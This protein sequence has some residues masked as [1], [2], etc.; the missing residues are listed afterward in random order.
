M[1]GIIYTRVSSGE[2]VEGTSLVFQEQVCRNYCKDKNIE[3]VQVFRE[4]GESAKDLS[5][6]NRQEFLKALDF[7]RK[8]KGEIEAFIVLRL[9]RFARNTED[10]FA[11]RKILVDYGTTLHSVTE[12]IDD[13]PTGKFFET[14]IAG[15]SEYENAIRK[16]QCTDGM[17]T[18]IKQGIYPWQPPVG[19]KCLNAKKHGEKKMLPDPP[20][21]NLFP[22]I[23]KGLKEY[24]TGV[25]TQLE[26]AKKFNE[27]GF[28]KFTGRKATPSV[29]N[30]ILTK[31][32]R[33]Y[34]GIIPNPWDGEE[35]KGKHKPMIT[36]EEMHL[37]IYIRTGKKLNVKRENF[38]PDFPLKGGLILCGEC[39]RPLTGSAS[40]GRK[41]YYPY[42]HCCNKSC[43]LYGKTIKKADLE[44]D[45]QE[46][47]KTITPNDDF[48]AL[49]KETVMDV[50]EE[51]GKNFELEANRCE[52]YLD[53]LREKKKRIFEMREDGSYTKEEF[54]ERKAEI[55]NQI[56][57]AKISFSEA[58]IEQFDIELALTYATKFIKDLGRQWFDMKEN[59]RPRFQKHILPEGISYT[60]S[61][62]FGTATL[63]LVYAINRDIGCD[64]SSL[65][66]PTGLE[67]ATSSVQTRRS[68]R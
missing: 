67:P 38:N 5:L 52:G 21:E 59:L 40:K 48:L 42:Y 45:F 47:L 51:K 13:S 22:I 60:K 62:G 54:D 61:D 18:K 50:W 28:E 24:A 49:F 12:P 44:R 57:S 20:D 3:V 32:L 7:C 19:Y 1:K 16:R 25:Y 34:A 56:A 11:V 9:N 30:R 14:I 2:Q 33:F 68:T 27:W 8:H 35:Y 65:V 63:G 64:K 58:K 36:E 39:G 53:E 37:I 15:A 31:Q 10:H 46:L 55:E 6:N 23:Q 66:D 4:E 29:I 41:G 17:S 43:G 26:L